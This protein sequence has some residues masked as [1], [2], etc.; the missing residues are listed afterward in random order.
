[1]DSETGFLLPLIGE[2]GLLEQQEDLELGLK[3]LAYQIAQQLNAS[4]CSIMLLNQAEN[5]VAEKSLHLFIHTGNL[6]KEAYQQSQQLNQGIAGRVAV[7]GK[8]LLVADINAS[9]YRNM[10]CRKGASGSFMSVPLFVNAEVIG[11]INVN[12]KR[13]GEPF[14]D[15]KLNLLNILSK[16]VGQSIH[17]FQ[18]QKLLSS[19]YL[20]HILTSGNNSDK[21][22]HS[23]PIAPDPVK[24]QKL[25]AKSFFRELNEAGFGANA[26]IGISGEIISLLNEK[27]CKDQQSH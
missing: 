12:A 17:L 13:E 7:S 20:Q 23:A 4:S 3:K 5:D 11:V 14:D 24:L 21:I 25:V 26:I 22:N 19:R 10:A 16:F 2:A 6:P 1:M 27:L 8:P 15:A 18:L 9:E